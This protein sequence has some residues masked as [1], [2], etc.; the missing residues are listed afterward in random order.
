MIEI[1]RTLT[2]AMKTSPF[3]GLATYKPLNGAEVQVR[4]IFNQSEASR[5]AG[6]SGRFWM[7]LADLPE[8][9]KK[10]D[11]MIIDAVDYQIYSD[12][13]DNH[14]GAGGLFLFLRK[15]Q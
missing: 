2:Q 9:A 15:T 10:L 12:I 6:V 4:G 8:N 13:N 14:D 5:G 3:S 11:H 7:L 1:F